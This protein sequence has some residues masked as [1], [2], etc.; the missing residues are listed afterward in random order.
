MKHSSPFGALLVGAALLT[1][2]VAA[3][4]QTAIA[5]ARAAA[6]N[7]TVSVRGVVTNGAEL[8]PIR[9]LQDGTGGIAAYSVSALTNIQVGDSVA[10]V[11]TLISFNGLLEI[12]PVTS[13]TVLASGRT[14]TPVTVPVAQAASV[15]AEQYESQLV[16]IDGNTSIT[17]SAGAPAST[18]SGNAN[19]RLNGNAATALR[20][21]AASTGTTG[22]VGKPVPTAGFDVVGLMSQFNPMGV[23]GYQLLPRLY[24]DFILGG[25]PNIT[26]APVV[27]NITTT[28]LEID[29]TTQN[30]GDGRVEYG[31]SPTAL[32]QTAVSSAPAGTQHA[33]TLTGLQPATV[34][35]VRINSTNAVGTSVGRVVPVI[36]QSLSSGRMRP[37]FT[38]SVDHAYAWPASNLAVDV[39]TAMRDS[40]AA[41]IDRAQ[42]TLDIAIYNWNDNTILNAVIR[43]KT[44]GVQVRVA[45][46]GTIANVSAQALAPNGIP[47]IERNTMR[48]I[49]HHKFLIVDANST[50][51]NRP[52]VWTGATNWTP[53]QLT[54]DRNS[55]IL[56]QDQ[57]LAKV[58]TMEFEEMWN[59]TGAT[60]GSA[61]KFGPLKTDNTPHYL[62]IGNTEVQSWFSPTDGTNTRLIETINTAD[63]DLHFASMLITRSDLALALRNRIQSQNILTCSEGLVNDTSGAGA[64][65]FR[66]IRAFMG[67]RLQ[68][69][70]NAGIMHHKYLLVDV[71]GSDPTTWESSHNW[72]NGAETD[73]DENTLVIHNARITNQY[74]QEF[75]QRMQDQNAGVVL[76]QLRAMGIANPLAGSTRLSARVYP[77]PT[78]GR[79]TVETSAAQRGSVQVELLDLN[80]RR[81]L[82]TTTTATPEGAIGLDADPLPAGLYHLRV[83]SAAGT[84][85]GR[86][87]VVK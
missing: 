71:A 61:P 19:Y 81:V 27:T 18:F 56:V 47:F 40:V 55:A 32:T 22:I 63:N 75:A 2:P 69:Y 51:P 52:L 49:M 48:G 21:N 4:A 14:V 23:G 13:I 34:Y 46:D 39:Q 77:N 7:S 84:Q 42:Q 80:G 9:Y 15:F 10:V 85:F 30:P 68:Y 70:N 45:Y 41:V 73:N 38:N 31:L 24:D 44:R 8:G 87:S 82:T 17:T 33:V 57:S 86:V 43:A 78:S 50:D 36:T 3:Q 1:A 76:C 65:P 83:T 20:V 59:S 62:K 12:S 58:Y 16:R 54:I 66:T 11:G 64:S 6:L 60:P 35:Y 72:S 53:G 67:P 28:S 25:T 29:F 79:F 5:V 26:S 37:W 74:Y